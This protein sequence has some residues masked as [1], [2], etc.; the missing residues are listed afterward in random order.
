MRVLTD[1]NIFIYREDNRVVSDNLQKLTASLQTFGVSVLVHPKSLDDLLRDC[2]A[3]RKAVMLSKVRAYPLLEKPPQ[4]KNDAKY[5]ALVGPINSPNSDVDNAI[6]YSVYRDAVDF[7]ITEDK[8]I[9]E[10]ARK[11]SIEDRVL[12]ISDALRFMDIY[13]AGDHVITPPALVQQPAYN[14]NLSDPIFDSLKACYP[15]FEAW[16]KKISREGRRSWVYV[17]EDGTIGALLIYKVEDEQIT[18]TP[19]LPRKKRLKVSSFK[20]TH[21]GYKIGELF[22]KIITHI[23]QEHSIDEIYFTVFPGVDDR[24]IELTSEYG[25]RKAGANCRGEEIYI[26]QLTAVASEVYAMRPLDIASRY[27]PSFYDGPLVRKFVVP[28]RPEYRDKLFTDICERQLHQIECNGFLVEGNTIRKAYLCHTKSKKMQPGDIII[29]YVGKLQNI[30]TLGVVES[31][32]YGLMGGLNLLRRVGKR[33][34]YS[35]TELESIGRKPTTVIMF[36]YHFHFQKT[37]AYKT[38]NAKKILKGPPQSVTQISDDQY[39][40]ILA[41]DGIDERYIV[42]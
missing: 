14:L 22:I 6:L 12:L 34:V 24:L 39:Q 35:Q 5:C 9:H 10:K 4:Y 20:V 37:I 3:Q 30:A 16:F 26:K 23:A 41:L 1:T 31:V 42:H 28:I 36:R 13:F 2:D 18:A 8:E 25:F 33:T 27:Y 17:Q 29:F 38:L 21:V 40:R 15:E 7:L 11:T 19:T 32:D